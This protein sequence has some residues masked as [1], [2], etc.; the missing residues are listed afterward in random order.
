MVALQPRVISFAITSVALATTALLSAC[1][2]GS[3]PSVEAEQLLGTW[4]GTNV[5]YEGGDTP[6]TQELRIV[7]KDI[8][9]SAFVGE[10]EWVDAQGNKGSDE[11]KGVVR[12]DG[13]VVI[14]DS[15]GV[16]EG[17]VS[18]SEFIGVYTEVG[19]E[20]T[21]FTVTMTKQ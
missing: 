2:S 19:E 16:I 10:K 13:G 18:A 8:N 12:P 11:F 6:V 1:S 9:G 21:A 15:D 5:G 17:T 7:I 4:V 20:P 3:S 14:V